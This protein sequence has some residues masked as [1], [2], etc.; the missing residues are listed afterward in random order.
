[1]IERGKIKFARR[2]PASHLRVIGLVLADRH[3]VMR[4]IW[5]VGEQV[6]QLNLHRREFGLLGFELRP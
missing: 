5:D 3:A 1:M 6:V 4:Q 2:T